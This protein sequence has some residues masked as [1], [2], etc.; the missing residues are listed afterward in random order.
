MSI[1]SGVIC[2]PIDPNTPTIADEAARMSNYESLHIPLNILINYRFRIEVTQKKRW[3]DPFDY[4]TDRLIITYSVSAE[5][6]H[7]FDPKKRIT[8]E[9]GLS[10]SRY[11]TE[12]SSKTYESIFDRDN[13][14]VLNQ[15][16]FLLALP[17]DQL[18]L[19]IDEEHH[20]IF[21]DLILWRFDLPKE[22]PFQYM[23]TTH[24][25]YSF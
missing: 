7:Q 13:M 8:M 15:I 12:A 25:P 18:P 21:Q 17:L 10:L 2:P 20:D 1:P 5:D 24:I 14:R 9:F 11:S 3:Q 19:Q 4:L 23:Y 6:L 16:Q 22:T